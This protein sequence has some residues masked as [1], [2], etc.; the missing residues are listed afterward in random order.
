MTGVQTCALP[1]FPGPGRRLEAPPRRPEQ[2]H[3]V[4]GPLGPHE[5]FGGPGLGELEQGGHLERDVKMVEDP[6]H[7]CIVAGSS[8][9]AIDWGELHNPILTEPS[10]G[11]KD[12]AIIWAGGRWHMLFSYVID[13]PTL[14]GGIRWNVATATSRDIA[15]AIS[16]SDH[17]SI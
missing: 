5:T 1:I 6:G 13:D 3:R 7:D 17:V 8:R 10:G 14:P 2:Q 11:V 12:Q 16:M 9:P 15:C 4:A